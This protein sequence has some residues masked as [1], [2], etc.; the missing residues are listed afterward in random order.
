MQAEKTRWQAVQHRPQPTSWA[1][2]GAL[3]RRALEP[4]RAAH[5]LAQGPADDEPKPR[6]PVQPGGGAARL[7]RWGWQWATWAAGRDA[8]G[9]WT[10]TMWFV[11][12]RGCLKT[13]GEGGA[14]TG[15][16]EKAVG[17]T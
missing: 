1:P 10:S 15:R 8:W 17:W 12:V 11:L 3:P 2:S 16:P 13:Q 14:P 4:H 9:H 6:P 7:G 5:R